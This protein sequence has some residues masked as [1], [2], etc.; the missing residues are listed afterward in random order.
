LLNERIEEAKELL[1][2][3]APWWTWKTFV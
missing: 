3:S 1:A 2:Q